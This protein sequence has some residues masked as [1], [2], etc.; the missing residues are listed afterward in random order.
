M[1]I[2]NKNKKS[3]KLTNKIIMEKVNNKKKNR[4]KL[5]VLNETVFTFLKY[6]LF[7]KT[8]LKFS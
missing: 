3:T 8:T 5:S 2:S 4:K 6:V 7:S 1:Q